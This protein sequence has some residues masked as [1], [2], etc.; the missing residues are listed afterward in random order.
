MGVDLPADQ[1]VEDDREG[2][3]EDEVPLVVHEP[4]EFGFGEGQCAGHVSSSPLLM[5]VG[6]VV[7][8]GDGEEGLLE[9]EAGDLDLARPVARVEDGVQRGVRVGRLDLHHVVPD[10]KVHQPGQA[11]QEG[12]V[13]RVQAEGE[14]LGPGPRLDLGGRAIGEQPAPVDDQDPVRRLV[15]LLQVV[16]GEQERAPRSH[17]F[18]HA[19]P[20]QPSGLH[21]HGR[22]RLVQHDQLG[23]A[24][25][26][27]REPDPLGLTSG[28]PVHPLVGELSD[29]G[30][31][32]R[33]RHRLRI[34]VQLG[35]EFDKLAHRHLGH[36][37]A[38]L[39]HGADPA[40]L[41]SRGT[42]HRRTS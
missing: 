2:H 40:G 28:Q 33:G 31:L 30:P 21:V 35:H 39:E 14:P 29:A 23:L 37:P 11:E 26:G 38:G 6:R 32:E 20:E 16:R 22:G 25:D 3:G 13:H 12:L 34:R 41:H 5:S 27:Q 17:L 24:A 19:A 4:A 18:L 7:F 8:G 9:A 1:E 42:G 10:L 15:G 36:Q